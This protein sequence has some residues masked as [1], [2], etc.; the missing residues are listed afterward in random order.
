MRYIV[1]LIMILCVNGVN[2]QMSDDGLFR[3]K[4]L[5]IDTTLSGAAAFNEKLI[6]D[7]IPGYVVKYV[8]NSRDVST[9]VKYLYE[10]SSSAILKIDY[11]YRFKEI[12]SSGRPKPVMFSQRITADKNTIALIY[13]YVFGANAKADELD[14]YRGDTFDF[15]YQDRD[16]HYSFI[17]DDYRPGYWILT[18]TP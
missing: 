10:H 7:C 3:A 9:E 16:Y 6:R 18:F 4:L 8:D 5:G 1:T 14:L 11:T 17:P 15:V 12:D 13:N 2:A